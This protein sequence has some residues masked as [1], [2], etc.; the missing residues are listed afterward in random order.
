MM[1]VS[2]LGS[3][4]LPVAILMGA[5]IVEQVEK[6]KVWWEKVEMKGC[7]RIVADV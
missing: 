7:Y 6:A 5:G 2:T 4:F 3:E 1:A